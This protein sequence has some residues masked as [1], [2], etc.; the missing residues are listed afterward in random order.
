[1]AINK[2]DFETFLVEDNLHVAINVKDFKAAV[3]HAET[4]DAKVTARYSRPFR[5]LQLTYESDGIGSEFTLMTRGEDNSNQDATPSSWSSTRVAAAAAAQRLSARQGSEAR[6]TR[7]N[8]HDNNHP[9]DGD[10]MPPPRGRRIRP[11]VGSAVGS[12]NLAPTTEEQRPAPSNGL[13]SLFV[14]ADDDRQWDEPNEDETAETEDM[15]GWD[16]MG[17]QVCSYSLFVE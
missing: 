1:M 11:L 17:D 15:L 12:Q 5:P 14:P 6:A 4:L 16:A 7:T 2:D 13:D 10:E 3:A 9:T 8:T